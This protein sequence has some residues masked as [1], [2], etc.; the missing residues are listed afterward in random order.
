[1][2]PAWEQ[3]NKSRVKLSRES[4]L[5]SPP[6]AQLLGLSSESST[7]LHTNSK[8]THQLES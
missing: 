3:V 7:P 2:Q 4:S 5:V 1:M 8:E 6:F